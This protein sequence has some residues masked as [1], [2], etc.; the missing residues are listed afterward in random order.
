[1]ETISENVEESSS[2]SSDAQPST[3]SYLSKQ[4]MLGGRLYAVDGLGSYDSYEKTPIVMITFPMAFRKLVMSNYSPCKRPSTWSIWC[5]PSLRIIDTAQLECLIAEYTDYDPL[6]SLHFQI[7]CNV[8]K[9]LTG[10]P[11]I[12]AVAG[13]HWQLVGFNGE[14][15]QTDLND[16][17]GLLNLLFL[18]HLTQEWTITAQDFYALSL[19]P[20]AEFPLARV[21]IDIGTLAISS[22]NL[23]LIPPHAK[24]KSIT[25]G[26]CRLHVALVK[27]FMR[28]WSTK[29]LTITNYGS[30]L[31][32]L[33]SKTDS[34]KKVA[35][36]MKTR[37]H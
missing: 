1:M 12:P 6:N 23:G 22:Y 15:P 11:L 19:V 31:Q 25:W 21:S 3:L 37:L 8:W 13:L 27:E 32:D 36:L 17:H 10:D 34:Y 9:R 5:F 24:E 14:H 20:G 30:L 29:C 33:Q 7:I 4:E 16:S 2:L 18:L 26:L 35:L 28:Q